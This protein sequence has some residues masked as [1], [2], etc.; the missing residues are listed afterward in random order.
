MFGRLAVV[1]TLLSLL[2]AGGAAAAEG[3]IGLLAIVDVQKV[4]SEASASTQARAAI[5]ARR[6][7]YERDLEAHKQ[8]LQSGQEQLQKQRAV[9]SPD[10]LEQRRRDL[11]QRYNDVRRQ[12]EERRAVLQEATQTAMNQLRQEMGTA[13]AEVMKANGIELTLPRSAV[14]VFDDKLDITGDVLATLNKRFPKVNLQL[15]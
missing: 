3:K 5:E 8:Q 11:E 9:L 12:T 7:G 13:I 6:Q 4:L 14:L 10:A 2:W 1:M 15:N